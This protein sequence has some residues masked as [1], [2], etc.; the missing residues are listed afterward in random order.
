MTDVLAYKEYITL[1]CMRVAYCTLITIQNRVQQRITIV[2]LKRRKLLSK[3]KPKQVTF[4]FAFKNN[5]VSHE[6]E[7]CRQRV[8]HRWTGDRE[9]M[10][11]VLQL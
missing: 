4:E 7:V 10:F 1:H 6:W 8:P 5:S 9:S 2:T 3:N 11:S